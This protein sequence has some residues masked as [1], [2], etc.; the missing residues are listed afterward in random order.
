MQE[1]RHFWQKK[2]FGTE[3]VLPYILFMKGQI[4]RH[5]GVSIYP[6]QR[7]MKI[8]ICQNNFVI[9]RRET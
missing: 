2:L 4:R 8:C 3:F 7:R 1:P 6:I 9:L 5:G